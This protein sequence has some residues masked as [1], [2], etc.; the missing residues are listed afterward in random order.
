MISRA[1]FAKG[2]VNKRTYELVASIRRGLDKLMECIPPNLHALVLMLRLLKRF[3]ITWLLLLR[4]IL[5]RVCEERITKKF[6]TMNIGVGNEKSTR[7][8]R[9]KINYFSLLS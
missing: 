8:E 3:D 2:K 5:H 6:Y 7:E 9:L 1:S 4:P